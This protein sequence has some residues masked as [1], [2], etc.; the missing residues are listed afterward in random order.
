MAICDPLA[1]AQELEA[2][3]KKKRL[4]AWNTIKQAS[5]EMAQFMTE[6]NLKM[7]KSAF[8]KVTVDDEIVLKQGIEQ[9]IRDM[10]IRISG[11]RW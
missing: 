6:I 3:A 1:K 2:R 10:T 8:I 5:P 4:D 7:G 11:K 9:G